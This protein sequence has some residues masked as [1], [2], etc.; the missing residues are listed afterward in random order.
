MPSELPFNCGFDFD[1]PIE[2]ER[3]TQ[4]LL[5]VGFAYPFAANLREPLYKK[6]AETD[7][8]EYDES[9]LA[10]YDLEHGVFEEPEGSGVFY[11]YAGSSAWDK[12]IA[13]G[14][15]TNDADKEAPELSFAA[16]MPQLFTVLDAI[17]ASSPESTPLLRNL[18][19]QWYYHAT[20]TQFTSNDRGFEEDEDD[21]EDDD[22]EQEDAEHEGKADKRKRDE[23]GS[24][25]GEQPAKRVKFAIDAGDGH[26]DAD[27]ADEDDAPA[28]VEAQ[29]AARLAILRSLLAGASASSG[30]S[31]SSSNGDAN[32]EANDDDDD[33]DADEFQ[34]DE[35]DN[36]EDDDE[37]DDEEDDEAAAAA[38]KAEAFNALRNK[39]EEFGKV[40]ASLIG[41]EEAPAEDLEAIG[42]AK[43]VILP[44]VEKL[45][46][47]L[48]DPADTII[49]DAMRKK[50]H[51]DPSNQWY[52]T[53]FLLAARS[54]VRLLANRAAIAQVPM[55]SASSGSA[56]TLGPTSDWA[57]KDACRANSCLF[58]GI[59]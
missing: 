8:F 19:A 9:E 44:V 39:R 41:A 53:R 46:A 45:N 14:L 35:D 5:D 51:N 13:D 10:V 12:L 37:E 55:G 32:A 7:G 17:H 34:P 57:R 54:R 38:H 52:R 27:D 20:E 18:A 11:C 15:L 36:E 50:M 42:A 3:P 23:Q 16:W 21:D 33:D 4:L 2:F 40:L 29:R 56:S 47:Y 43:A 6:T 31:S 28:S 49:F 24:V 48:P 25:E 30:S 58:V 22:E 26:D 59:D 1:E